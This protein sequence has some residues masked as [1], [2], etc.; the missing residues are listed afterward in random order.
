MANL[1][2]A[3]LLLESKMVSL[4]RLQLGILIRKLEKALN[5]DLM[6]NH[7]CYSPQDEEAFGARL[8]V[9]ERYTK[10]TTRPNGNDLFK[11]AH[12]ELMGDL[13]YLTEEG[14]GIDCEDSWAVIRVLHIKTRIFL[15][16][17]EPINPNLI[18][19]LDLVNSSDC[20]YGSSIKSGLADTRLKLNAQ[21][22]PNA[23]VQSEKWIKD[24]KDLWNE[25][26][27][28]LDLSVTS[29]AECL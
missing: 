1:T 8:K 19:S 23:D 17:Q 16:D 27:I 22:D 4:P 5:V 3:F 14:G 25:L 21:L 11:S 24:T 9:L 2:P 12:K 7:V 13:E 28:T 15:A 18:F 26:I 6:I 20:D 10:E 29:C